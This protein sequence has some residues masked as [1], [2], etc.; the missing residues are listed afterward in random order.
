M[1]C[2][3]RPKCLRKVDTP[4]DIDYFKPRQVPMTELDVNELKVE[5]LEAVRLVDL[6]GKDLEEAAKKMG[7]SRRTLSRELKSAHKKI[8]DSLLNAK[9]IQIR[10]GTYLA[11]HERMFKC[12]DNGHQWKQDKNKKPLKCPQCDS[13][14]IQKR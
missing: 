7:V 8:A 1:T 14:N 4:P 2:R 11:K 3:G 10:G 6:E 9:A 13:T 5:E 12:K